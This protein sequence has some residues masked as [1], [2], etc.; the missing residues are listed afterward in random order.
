MEITVGIDVSKARL[1]VHVHPL[2]ESFA[3][4]NDEAGVAELVERLGRLDGLMCIGIEASGRYERLAVAEL[5][6]AC[7]PVVVLNP[8]QVR[9]YA[10]AIGLRAKTDPID[11]RLIALFVEAV[12]PEPRPMAERETQDLAALMARRRQLVQMLAAERMRRAQATPGPVRLS[13]ARVVTTLEDALRELDGNIDTTVRGTPV[14]RDKEDLLASVP[15]IG[16][17]IART[18]L[19]E[20][21]ELGSL[22][23]KQ[24]AAL[25]G[26]A[27]YTRQS[28]KWRGKSFIG[29]G[30]T[31]VRTALFMGALVAARYNPTLKAFRDRLVAAGKPKLVAIIATARKLL[32]ILNAIIRDQKPWKTA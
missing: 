30:R 14:W 27:P 15:G 22:S 4:G 1:D 9:H 13:L 16:K 7:L 12:R 32:T 19:A 24:I 10:Q 21:P 17:T 29:G 2:G 8:A 11:A 5:A 6:G 18:L 28:G 25:A 26:L 31:A 20:L 3:A 23:P